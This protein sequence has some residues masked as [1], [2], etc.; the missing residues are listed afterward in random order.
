MKLHR[1]SYITSFVVLALTIL[2]GVLFGQG[3]PVRSDE[4]LIRLNAARAKAV[5]HQQDE[6]KWR[7]RQEF[8]QRF[9]EVIDAVERFSKV[10][11][12]NQGNVWPT[13][14]AI[15]L[16]KAIQRLQSTHDWA[17]LRKR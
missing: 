11:N 9:N 10:Y 6:L 12:R 4:T 3:D 14:E 1:E 15:G 8:E 13:K 7:E 2:T 5:E 16:D 17:Q